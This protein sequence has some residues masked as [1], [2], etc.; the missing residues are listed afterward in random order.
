MIDPV[1]EGAPTLGPPIVLPAYP[2]VDPCDDE[3]AAGGEGAEGGEEWSL[4]CLQ[5]SPAECNVDY[6]S[7]SRW[8]ESSISSRTGVCESRPLSVTDFGDSLIECEQAEQDFRTLSEELT[9]PGEVWEKEQGPE[10]EQMPPSAPPPAGHPVSLT[11]STQPVRSKLMTSRDM[12]EVS[13]RLYQVLYGYKYEL[14]DSDT[15]D[16]DAIPAGVNQ[17]EVEAAARQT[18]INEEVSNSEHEV[19]V[20]EATCSGDL[21]VKSSD[22]I[23]QNPDTAAQELAGSSDVSLT[24]PGLTSQKAD[25]MSSV[26]FF[27]LSH[28]SGFEKMFRSDLPG[29]EVEF[30]VEST[31]DTEASRYRSCSPESSPETLGEP[32]SSVDYR[33]CSPEYAIDSIL[34]TE[35]RTSSPDSASLQNELNFLAPD[36]AVPQIRPLSPL[37]PT[38]FTWE[39]S[40]SASAQ[41]QP[42]PSPPEG[43]SMLLASEA[44]E[45]P[46]VS[47]KRPFGRS[48]SLSSD[49]SSERPISPQSLTFDMDDRTSSPESVIL[50]TEQWLSTSSENVTVF[51]DFNELRSSSPESIMSITEHCL[52][53]PDSPIPQFGHAVPES[54][55]TC[56]CRS[57]S[58]ESVSSDLVFES[59]LLSTPAFEDRP[60]SPESV[61]SLNENKALSPD[62]P[63]PQFSPNCPD[64]A[65]VMIGE[66]FSSPESVCSDVEYGSMSPA[67]LNRDNRASSPASVESMD[68]YEWVL[69][70][71]GPRVPSPE[72][73]ESSQ[74]MYDSTSVDHTPKSP[75]PLV[76]D[77][78]NKPPTPVELVSDNEDDWDIICLSEIEKCSVTPEPVSE[79]RPVSPQSTKF[80][81]C[82]STPQSETLKEVVLSDTD[83]EGEVDNE[84]KSKS[85]VLS[86]SLEEN[87]PGTDSN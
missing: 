81:I 72:S 5:T 39:T 28:D 69:P 33:S 38:V 9:E 59:R 22:S 31:P 29:N 42:L 56:D 76:F 53:Q 16:E 84:E 25:V 65:I 79:H 4:E 43:T 8:R 57:S 48:V 30:S 27:Q 20:D 52:L 60:S 58:P 45:T 64:P 6:L 70:V 44:E 71:A 35:N 68:E 86:T 15:V 54:V 11:A 37:P 55:T 80:G 17:D 1:Y 73:V 66:R 83:Y 49:H 24:I 12:D 14:I 61:A 32:P 74:I 18:K 40:D 13:R 7:L 50:E 75:E 67:S 10:R 63:I 23:N 19:D 34:Q 77:V 21:D 2:S 82:A 62:S 41:E 47:N 46:M 78:K 87:P 51:P 85:C 3:G 36:P 26:G